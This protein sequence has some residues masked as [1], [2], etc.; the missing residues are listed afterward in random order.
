VGEIFNLSNGTTS[1]IGIKKRQ[2]RFSLPCKFKLIVSNN[3]L[4]SQE[5]NIDSFVMGSKNM[6][7]DSVIEIVNLSCKE[8]LDKELNNQSVYLTPII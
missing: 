2:S 7:N 5:I 6:I 8:Q 4:L 1:I 3:D